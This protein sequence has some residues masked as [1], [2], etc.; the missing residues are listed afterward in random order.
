MSLVG[1]NV[2][3][4]QKLQKTPENRISKVIQLVFGLFA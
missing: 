4:P 3:L 2:I 1:P